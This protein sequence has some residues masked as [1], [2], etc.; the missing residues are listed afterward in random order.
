M[1]KFRENIEILIYIK[2][3]KLYSLLFKL[4][5][6]KKFILQYILKKSG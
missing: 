1:M 3:L 4:E 2:N 6:K 5:F